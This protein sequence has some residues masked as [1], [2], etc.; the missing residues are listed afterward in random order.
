MNLK[1]N[2]YSND[3]KLRVVKLFIDNKYSVK[4]LVELFSVSKSSIYNWINTYKNSNLL[5]KSSYVKVNSKF[6]NITIREF[7][8]KYV[9]SNPNLNYT[10]LI[11][12]INNGCNKNKIEILKSLEE[13]LNIKIETYEIIPDYIHLFIRGNLNVCVSTMMKY[14]KGL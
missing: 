3:I 13:K 10:E 14:L 7:I 11:Q 8:L 2:C 4:Q 6:R 5:Q 1:S 9:S 12:Q